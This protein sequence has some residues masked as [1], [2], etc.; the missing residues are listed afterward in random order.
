[1]PFID[2]ESLNEKEVFPGYKGRAIH[3]GTATYIYWKVDAGAAVPEHSHKHE[4]VANVL[5]GVFE[6]T[7][8]GE[9]KLLE[10][11]KA[12]VIPSNIKHSGRA[13]TYCELLDVF[14]PERED[15]KF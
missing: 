7:V 2:I 6:L 3:T 12:A 11:G 5:Q 1:M 14:Y 9:T 15:Y 8:D 13:I 10:P 4:Q